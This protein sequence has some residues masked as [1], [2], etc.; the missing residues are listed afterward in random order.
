M[1]NVI[2]Q[3]VDNTHEKD[4]KSFSTIA[5]QLTISVM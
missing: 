5:L 2:A 1:S 4:M 3:L